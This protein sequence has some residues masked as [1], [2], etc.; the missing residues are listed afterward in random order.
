MVNVA[1]SSSLTAHL[2]GSQ[3]QQPAAASPSTPA[4]RACQSS[5]NRWAETPGVVWT[6]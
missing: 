3:P 6:R 5:C 1:L 4:L 2:I